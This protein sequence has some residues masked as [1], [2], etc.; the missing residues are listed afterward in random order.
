MKR[1]RGISSESLALEASKY[2][3]C[4]GIGINTCVDYDR[5]KWFPDF[6][7]DEIEVNLKSVMIR[8]C[9]PREYTIKFV[10]KFMR[11]LK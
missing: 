1:L 9:G 7:S 11:I 4:G 6:L 5:L 3:V 2:C 8:A 10:I